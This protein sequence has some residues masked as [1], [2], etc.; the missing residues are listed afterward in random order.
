MF[1]SD[2]RVFRRGRGIAV[3]SVH[4]VQEVPEDRCLRI[5][6]PHWMGQRVE[7]IMKKAAD[8]ETCSL[9][10]AACAKLQQEGGFLKEVL[11][12]AHEDVWNEL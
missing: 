4:M 1:E 10:T 11:G 6:V 2:R 3:Q 5:K 7:L 12:S 9:E 8:E